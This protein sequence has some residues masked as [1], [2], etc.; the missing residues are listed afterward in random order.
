MNTAINLGVIALIVLLTLGGHL[1]DTHSSQ[2]L[3]HRF[4]NNFTIATILGLGL[5][6]RAFLLKYVTIPFLSSGLALI[7]I[8]SLG[9]LS[10][11]L[12]NMKYLNPVKEDG[13]AHKR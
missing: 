12:L 11:H 4:L 6:F 8:F 10:D 1:E 9:Y 3:A 2:T 5:G 13:K 7:L